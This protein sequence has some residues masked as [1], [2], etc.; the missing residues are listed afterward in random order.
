MCCDKSLG[1]YHNVP[2]GLGCVGGNIDAMSKFHVPWGT[3]QMNQHL[4]DGIHAY[5]PEFLDRI[6]E[7]AKARGALAERRLLNSRN[8]SRWS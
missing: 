7:A 1:E 2:V 4:K 3:V 8:P 6:N 5:G